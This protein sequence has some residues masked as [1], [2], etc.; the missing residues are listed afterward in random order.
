MQL[1]YETSQISY[2]GVCYNYLLPQSRSPSTGSIYY[3]HFPLPPDHSVSC[4]SIHYYNFTPVLPVHHLHS[5]CNDL[6]HSSY[7]IVLY[8]CCSLQGSCICCLWR[9]QPRTYCITSSRTSSSIMFSS[10]LRAHFTVSNS[11]V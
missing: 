3:T 10:F 7:W 6:Q 4:S 1:S 2:S 9:Q 11:F 8:P 5:S